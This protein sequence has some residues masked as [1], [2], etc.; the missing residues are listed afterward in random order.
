MKDLLISYFCLIYV[1]KIICDCYNER[2]PISLT[3]REYESLCS[4]CDIF[5]DTLNGGNNEDL[6]QGSD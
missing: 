3:H 4:V 6:A 2:T 1:R 5:L